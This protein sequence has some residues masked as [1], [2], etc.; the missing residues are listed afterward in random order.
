MVQAPFHVR[1]QAMGKTAV[2]AA[3]VPHD[4]PLSQADRRA[5]VTRLIASHPQLSDRAIA[6]VAGLSAKTVAAIRRRSTDAVPQLNGRVGRD[7]RV[8]PVNGTAGRPRAAA[9]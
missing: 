3:N 8:R 7:G 1:L 2:V 6:H 4:M 9:F 5:A